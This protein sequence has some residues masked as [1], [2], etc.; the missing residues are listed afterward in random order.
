MERFPR[1]THPF[2]RLLQHSSTS[3]HEQKS[4]L[5]SVAQR[6]QSHVS[7]DARK[8]L[9]VALIAWQ[10][11]RHRPSTAKPIM[12][13][14]NHVPRK[15][16]LSEHLAVTD[17]DLILMFSTLCPSLAV[18]VNLA[19]KIVASWPT[20]HAEREGIP[21]EL[22]KDPIIALCQG[23]LSVPS[24]AQRR[25]RD[26]QERLPCVFHKQYCRDLMVATFGKGAWQ[27]YKYTRRGRL[28]PLQGQHS[29]NFEQVTCVL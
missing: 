23:R 15:L 1:F 25:A 11:F 9:K 2:V 17:R 22:K 14:T 26:L 28:C 29:E 24:K 27:G 13:S 7:M 16:S 5:L 6:L 8:F 10:D 20:R 19:G 21:R 18:V 3:D 4:I 12:T